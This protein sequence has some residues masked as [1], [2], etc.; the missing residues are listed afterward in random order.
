[1]DLI[2][3]KVRGHHDSPLRAGHPLAQLEIGAGRRALNYL[4]RHRRTIPRDAVDAP[5]GAP[6]RPDLCRLRSR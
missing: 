2:V 4:G 6:N 1:M 3:L 5:P